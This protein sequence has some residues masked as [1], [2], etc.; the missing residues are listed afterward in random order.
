MSHAE[1]FIPTE[2]KIVLC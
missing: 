2:N 1:Y